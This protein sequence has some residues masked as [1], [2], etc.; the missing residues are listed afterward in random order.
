GRAGSWAAANEL[1]TEATPSRSE[2][3]NDLRGRNMWGYRGCVCCWVVAS[4]FFFPPPLPPALPPVFLPKRTLVTF[5]FPSADL[6]Y[7]PRAGWP[8][9]A[10]ANVAGLSSA[11]L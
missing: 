9:T 4:V 3:K 6:V 11:A 7:D 2:T 10:S 5:S 8:T 1:E